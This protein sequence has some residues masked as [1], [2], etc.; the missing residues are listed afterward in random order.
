VGINANDV[1]TP[2]LGAAVLAGYAVLAVTAGAM[3]MQRR[4][5]A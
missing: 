4:D 1:L 3:L 5:I 2:V